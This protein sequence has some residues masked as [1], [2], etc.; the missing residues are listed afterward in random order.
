MSEI[1]FQSDDKSFTLYHG[2]CLDVLPRLVT[3]FG[4]AYADLVFADPPY[5]LSNDGITCQS[6]KMVSVNKGGWDKSNGPTEDH[7]MV[8]NWLKAARDAMKPDATIWITGTMHIIYNIGFA[9]QELHFKLLNDIVWV[10]PAPPPNLACRTFTHTTEIVLWAARNDG[11]VKGEKKSKY[12]FNYPE[13]KRQNG[14]KQMRSFWGQPPSDEELLWLPPS[15]RV[16]VEFNSTRE[17]GTSANVFASSPPMHRADLKSAPTQPDDSRKRPS[18]RN[19]QR[20]EETTPNIFEIGAP[21]SDEKKFGKHPTQK[22]M[23]LLRRIIEAGSNP[24]QMVVDPFNGTGA[25][26]IM[27]A[28][29]GRKYIGVESNEEYLEITRKRYLEACNNMNER[30]YFNKDK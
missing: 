28:M 27:A 20:T 8:K 16:G 26:G 1:Y 21:R 15:E 11:L 2:D 14:G 23:A 19:V 9:L 17:D 24:G 18:D 10:K 3:T 13:M 12:V 4:D 5:Y 6:G 22:P 30:F 29:L 7:A 25:T